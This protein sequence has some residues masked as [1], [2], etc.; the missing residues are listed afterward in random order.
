VRRVA[1]TEK[2]IMAELDTAT[3][4]L[5][6]AV[7]VAP[8]VAAEPAAAALE[9]AAKEVYAGVPAVGLVT[10][11]GNGR[12]SYVLVDYSF[13]ST[14]RVLWA[15]AGDAWRYRIISDAQVAG[16]AKAVM[17][18]TYVDVWWTDSSMTFVRCWKKF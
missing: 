11:A 8:E 5:K 3:E 9:Q 16:I 7:A 18:S 13:T 14:Q 1:K 17:E 4:K 12:A 2:E 6:A 10:A 15:Y